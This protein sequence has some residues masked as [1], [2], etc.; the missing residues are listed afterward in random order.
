MYSTSADTE[1]R[2][3][4]RTYSYSNE[5]HKSVYG[6]GEYAFRLELYKLHIKTGL[7]IKY[8]QK[9]WNLFTNIR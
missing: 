7:K 9:F 6:N 4:T 5:G 3:H 2:A 1:L 8:L